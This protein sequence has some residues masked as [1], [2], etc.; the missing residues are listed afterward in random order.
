VEEVMRKRIFILGLI[1]GTVILVQPCMGQSAGFDKMEV[2]WYA[3][4][5]TG[6]GF[7]LER[8]VDFRNTGILHD[9][10]L[11]TV[12]LKKPSQAFK[13]RITLEDNGNLEIELSEGKTFVFG[14]SEN[15]SGL[16]LVF[17]QTGKTE[18][19]LGANDSGTLYAE[20]KGILTKIGE[21]KSE[22]V[23]TNDGQLVRAVLVRLLKDS[24][25]SFV[26]GD[27]V[28]TVDDKRKATQVGWAGWRKITL[29]SG[30]EII[31][32]MLKGMSD[33]SPWR[34][35]YDGVLYL[36]SASSSR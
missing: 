17:Q 31:L 28:Y 10:Y 21:A 6:G 3:V 25:W 26:N 30:A 7:T 33:K 36:D 18:K 5:T 20:K 1:L 4:K 34:G 22:I 23:N 11:K 12:I 2:A 16:P 19:R 13:S 35:R 14:K 32:Y 15:Q 9:K 27:K 24:N 8:V 29:P